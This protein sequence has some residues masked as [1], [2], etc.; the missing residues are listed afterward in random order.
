MEML[1]NGKFTAADDGEKIEVLNPADGALIDTVPRGKKN[2]IN[3]AVCAAFWK[4]RFVCRLWN[5]DGPLARSI[6]SGVRLVRT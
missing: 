1:I 3:K 2:D 6:G 4:S 5:W